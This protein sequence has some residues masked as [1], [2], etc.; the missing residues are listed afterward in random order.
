MV[1]GFGGVGIATASSSSEVG[2]RR[3]VEN[4][5]RDLIGEVPLHLIQPDEPMRQPH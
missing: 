1:F 4:C 3:A 2:L 5:R